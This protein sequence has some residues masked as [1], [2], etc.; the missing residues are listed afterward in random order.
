MMEFGS[1]GLLYIGTGDGGGT[2]NNSL[3]PTRLLGKMLRIDIDH[4]AAGMQY[5]IPS[6]NPFAN[7][8]GAPEVWMLGLRNPWRWSFDRPTG[9]LWLPDVGDSMIEEL[10]V[11]APA[12]EP[13]ANLG[14]SMYEGSV[15][16][17]P[18]CDP[19]GKI[20]PKDER[21]H[22]AWEAIIGGQVYRGTCY[23][24]LVGWYFYGD[25]GGAYA[26]AQLRA[27]RSLDVVDLTGSFPP[28]PT[29]F[30]EDA[31]HEIYMTDSSGFVYHLEAGPP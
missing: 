6:D 28:H 13:A 29:S 9:D 26:K 18:P 4:Q 23:P 15:C 2:N 31:H 25:F 14:W 10:N 24:D 16:A 12:E 7:G 19:T 22:P 11:L 21:T 5:A 8:G 3:D 20:F 30:H 27:D 1:D 17:R